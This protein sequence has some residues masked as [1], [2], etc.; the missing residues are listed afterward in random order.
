MEPA[1]GLFSFFSFF[2]ALREK[3]DPAL[4]TSPADEDALPFLAIPEP[5]EGLGSEFAL[6]REDRHC[7][8]DMIFGTGAAV[9]VHI[10]AAAAVLMAP[11]TPPSQPAPEPV[12]RVYM[13]GPEAFGN[14][15]AGG[16]EG[17]RNEPPPALA[18]VKIAAPDVSRAA[19]KAERAVAREK[20]QRKKIVKTEAKPVPRMQGS[21]AAVPA[22]E[23]AAPASV[24]ESILPGPAA[25]GDPGVGS[26]ASGSPG[27]P[28][29]GAGRTQGEFEAAAVDQVPQVLVKNPPVYP[30]KARNMGIGGKVVL[31][32]LVGADGH[33]SRPAVVEAHPAGYFEQSAMDAV[34]RWRF[35]PGCVKGRA[36]ATWV[37]LPVQFRLVDQD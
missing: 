10:A 27:G 23:A 9:L 25:A 22:D 21:A 24:A 26:G 7:W 28:S 19:G 12:L 35:K 33:V 5:P 4:A 20:P 37:T 34:S 1:S 30:N 6:S 15:D 8:K 32:F 36:V 29:S 31:R 13:A 18:E 14:A 2:S 3:N 11:F 17:G 16:G